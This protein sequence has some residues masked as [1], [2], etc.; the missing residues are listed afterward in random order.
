MA[1]LLA[2]LQIILC[3]H[4]GLGS[5]DNGSLCPNVARN[6]VCSVSPFLAAGIVESEKN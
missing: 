5:G 4:L 2:R 6:I 1:A 3:S